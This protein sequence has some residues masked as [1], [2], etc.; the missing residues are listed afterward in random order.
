LIIELVLGGL[1]LIVIVAA[2]FYIGWALRGARAQLQVSPGRVFIGREAVKDYGMA[3]EMQNAALQTKAGDLVEPPYYWDQNIGKI[4]NGAKT[5][6]PYD[7][8]EGMF[9]DQFLLRY[10]Y[11]LM[12]DVI[13]RSD[14]AILFWLREDS[15]E[16]QPREPWSSFT[17]ACPWAKEMPLLFAQ[18]TGYTLNGIQLNNAIAEWARRLSKTPRAATPGPRE[19][20]TTG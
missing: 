1:A 9:L 16:L 7:D 3:R 12:P 13:P 6:I 2:A 17:K 14:G 19:T 18:M 8:L 5:S 10:F 20:Q 4:T 15:I 11:S